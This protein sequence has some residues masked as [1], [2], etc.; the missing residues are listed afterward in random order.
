[1]ANKP[2]VMITGAGTGI[3]KATALAFA[4]AH[5]PLLLLGRRIAPLRALGLDGAV[6][7][8]ADVTDRSAVAAAIAQGEAAHEIA[9]QSRKA[10]VVREGAKGVGREQ[11]DA[12]EKER[13][14]SDD[15]LGGDPKR[16]QQHRASHQ[17]R[18]DD[19]PANH[20]VGVAAAEGA[21]MDVGSPRP[22]T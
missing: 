9:D 21:V 7:V 5:Y 22:A 19:Q 10:E 3:G 4:R 2:L 6:C 8:S 12:E 17:E 11:Q 1:M 15:P 18:E 16:L 20:Q 13:A 14:G